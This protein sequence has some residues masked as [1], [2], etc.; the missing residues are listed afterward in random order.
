MIKKGARPQ[1]G[2]FLFKYARNRVTHDI[3]QE[4][5]LPF[6]EELPPGSPIEKEFRAK[7]RWGDESNV[8]KTPK[9]VKECY[10]ILMRMD[11]RS[12]IKGS[13]FLSFQCLIIFLGLLPYI[14]KD[15]DKLRKGA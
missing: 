4:K 5:H 10:K 6:K 14:L 8:I 1:D 11:T 2:F 3:V 15:L 13:Y 9:A 7:V 12:E